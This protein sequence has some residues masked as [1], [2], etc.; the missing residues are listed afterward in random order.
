MTAS[1]SFHEKLKN[2]H[3]DPKIVFKIVS[4]IT[5]SL[6]VMAYL[7]MVVL[8]VLSLESYIRNNRDLHL[9]PIFSAIFPK[10]SK[11]DKL[12]RIICFSLPGT[13]SITSYRQTSTLKMPHISHFP[14]SQ[15]D[16]I[17]MKI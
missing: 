17:Q 11:E 6:I 5:R 2:I 16:Q 9:G 10:L 12:L 14:A 13:G 8:I 7:Q 15:T 3:E 1:D 4:K